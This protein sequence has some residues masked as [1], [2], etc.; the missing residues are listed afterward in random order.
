MILIEKFVTWQPRL[1]RLLHFFTFYSL[2]STQSL[3]T[4]P[5]VTTTPSSNTS[6]NFN[7]FSTTQTQIS[8]KSNPENYEHLQWTSIIQSY[9]WKKKKR[10]LFV[11]IFSLWGLLLLL[12]FYSLRVFT[13]LVRNGCH[14]IP[15]DSKY[16]HI[17]KI[18]SRQFQLFSSINGLYPSLD[19]QV[20]WSLFQDI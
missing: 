12:L 1:C 8:F 3:P 14:W 15:S 17:S 20:S 11:N 6:P 9:L 16:L 7:I 18:Y 5:C 4:H 2:I 13:W 19:L 10:L